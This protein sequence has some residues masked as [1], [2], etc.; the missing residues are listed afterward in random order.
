MV[1][2]ALEYAGNIGDRQQSEAALRWVTSIAE[3]GRRH[4]QGQGWTDLQWR[5]KLKSRL[6]VINPRLPSA[7]TLWRMEP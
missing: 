5:R 4:C 6:V 2:N 1:V 3:N 7:S